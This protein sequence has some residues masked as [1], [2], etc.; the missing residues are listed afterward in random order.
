MM[1]LLGSSKLV[2]IIRHKLWTA[3]IINKWLVFYTECPKSHP[4]H[5][6]LYVEEIKTN[7]WASA[8][9]ICPNELI[10]DS[11]ENVQLPQN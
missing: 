11:S 2:L 4:S 8:H 7:N 9:F 1:Y 10:F 3:I 5:K 6:Y